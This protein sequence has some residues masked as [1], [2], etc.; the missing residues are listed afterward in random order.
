MLP[1]KNTLA[2][3]MLGK[4]K[5]YAGSDHPHHAQ[6]PIPAKFGHQAGE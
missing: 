5:V 2:R 4:L 1:K 6:K 3:H